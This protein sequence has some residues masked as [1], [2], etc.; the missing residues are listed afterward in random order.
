[1][2]IGAVAGVVGV[3]SAGASVIGAS[4]Q[5]KAA[6]NAVE[7]QTEATAN[8]DRIALEIYQDQ[9]ARNEPFRQLGVAAINPFADLLGLDYQTDQAAQPANVPQQYQQPQPSY[10]GYSSGGGVNGFNAF[11]N[12]SFVGRAG[13]EIIR[14]NPEQFNRRDLGDYIQNGYYGDERDFA[15]NIPNILPDGQGG[16][17][18]GNNIGKQSLTNGTIKSRPAGYYGPTPEPTQEQRTQN[19]FN[20]LRERPGFQFQFDQ[21]LEAI[22]Q[23]AASRGM[24]LSGAQQKALT[25]YGQDYG[26]NAYDKELNRLSLAMGGGQV[27]TNATN[28]AAGAYGAQ[29]SA[30]ALNLGN[31]RASAYQ[32]Q[33]QASAN[34]FNG[35]AGG[36]AGAAGIYSG[37]KG[38]T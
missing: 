35:I 12:N 9:A 10:G 22:D 31:A 1:M 26:S 18:V 3:A 5:R 16:Y 34:A 15:G 13:N 14:R 25:Q 20:T 36:I 7:A 38:W 28:Q 33:G 19:A 2:P 11:N 32:Q 23:S 24:L 8:S 17:R 4:K 29:T 30:N 21:G 37:A 27:A 6:E